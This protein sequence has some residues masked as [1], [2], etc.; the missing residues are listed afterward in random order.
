ML[1]LVFSGK[2]RMPYL[3]LDGANFGLERDGRGR[4]TWTLDPNDPKPLTIPEVARA[5][6]AGTRLTYRDQPNALVLRLAV[7]PVRAAGNRVENAVRLSGD[8]SAR[9]V[10]IKLSG[11]ID[12]PNAALASQA[13]RAALTLVAAE[14]TID[15]AGTL[16][17]PT[18]I[19]G[20]ELKVHARGKN[21]AGPFTLLGTTVPP[22]RRYDL[23]SNLTKDGADWKFTRLTGTFGDSDLAGQ[24]TVRYRASG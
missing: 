6:I 14:S 3:F 10:P 12:N 11:R 18:V 23:R 22:T 8:G 21:I 19:E 4:N 7:D 9:G 24:M 2:R 1:P 5:E 16:P 15:V 13:T 17:G 20:A